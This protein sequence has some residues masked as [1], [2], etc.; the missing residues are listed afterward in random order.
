[1]A[2]VPAAL[3]VNSASLAEQVLA[4]VVQGGGYS[5]NVVLFNSS[6]GFISN[7]S[8]SSISITG[9]PLVLSTSPSQ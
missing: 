1:M 6:P 3:E 8:I 4:Q 9:R 5:T 2:A 7:G